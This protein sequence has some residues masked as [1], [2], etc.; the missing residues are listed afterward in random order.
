[1][2][3]VSAQASF[4]RRAPGAI[5]ATAAADGARRPVRI[6]VLAAVGAVALHTGAAA[7]ALATMQPDDPPAEL[8]TIAFEV[9]YERAAPKVEPVDLP[10]GPNSDAS[11]ASP[12]VEKQQ[13]IV[14]DPDLPQA[15]PTETEDPDRVVTP[16][17]KKKPVVDETETPKAPTLASAAAVA[18]EATAMPSSPTATVAPRS[19]APELGNGDS[20]RRVR[21]AWQ[22]E[23]SA[24]LTRFKRYPSDRSNR[25]ADIV[26]S[27]VLDRTGHVISA[28]VVQ[29]SG[30]KSFDEAA[31]AMIRR[32]DPVPAP[33][34]LVADEGLT[35]TVP[36]NFR[37]KGH[38]DRGPATAARGR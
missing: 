36:V 26:V 8:G 27:F 20:A 19:T 9:D 28:S 38:D 17:Q 4:A 3:V 37:V 33:P 16:D 25:N 32:A 35:F 14:K 5:A 11:A 23:L 21:A 1:V 13:E 6:W 29:G 7:L 18:S 12:A 30:D 15:K 2:T 10:P 31:V 22:K 24:H 34:A